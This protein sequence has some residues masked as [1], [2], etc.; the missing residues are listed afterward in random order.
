M[1]GATVNVSDFRSLV[2]EEVP[3]ASNAIVDR[4]VLEACINF[5]KLTGIW[6]VKLDAQPVLANVAEY[7][8]YVPRETRLWSVLEL[9]Y[10]GKALTA[11]ELVDLERNEDNWETKLGV[12]PK[13]YTMLDSQT[14][15]LIGIPQERIE[16]ALTGTVTVHP[17]RTAT[18][19][20]DLLL[21]DWGNEIADG[22]KSLLL[23]MRNTPW[24]DRTRA[25]ELVSA[26][27]GHVAKA[28]SKASSGHAKRAIRRTRAHFM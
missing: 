15:R 7:E 24:Y 14:V 6:I 18:T 23:G 28:T 9:K 21:E 26:F 4:K 25:I 5:C 10:Q 3:T 27:G 13:E 2:K 11:R 22:A 12:P 16:R 19:V 8:L 20:G 17:A 1:S